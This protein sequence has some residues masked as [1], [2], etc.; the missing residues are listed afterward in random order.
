MTK[1]LA[2]VFALSMLASSWGVAASTPLTVTSPDGNLTA[3]IEVKSNPQPYLPGRRLYYKIVYH[4]AAILRDSPLGL[5]FIGAP[6]LDHDF[7]ITNSTHNSHD[8]TWEDAFGARRVVPDHYNQLTVSL[9]EGGALHRR[10]DIIFKAYNEGVAFR[11]SLPRQDGLEKF[12]LSSENTGFYF[13]R[14]ATAFASTSNRFLNGY[15]TQFFP[16]DVNLIKPNAMA[17]LPMLVHLSAGPW[18]A[19]LEADLRDYAGMYLG[20]VLGVPDSLTSRLAPLPDEFYEKQFKLIYFTAAE[21]VRGTTPAV[22]PWRIVV[23]L[24]H[25]LDN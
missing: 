19:V 8:E 5:D 9:Q 12:I 1:K 16:L 17:V 11:Y 4:G 21:A 20:G 3:S 14:P 10:M 25:S 22:S 18:L 24:L 7:Q 2:S 23:W 13:A 15:E 6:P